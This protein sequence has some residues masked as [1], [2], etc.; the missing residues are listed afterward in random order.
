MELLPDAF[1][2]CVSHPKCVPQCCPESAG[3]VSARQPKYPVLRCSIHSGLAF[4]GKKGLEHGKGG[5]HAGEKRNSLRLPGSPLLSRPLHS[6]PSPHSPF[7]SR[8]CLPRPESP[9]PPG[10]TVKW[11]YSRLNGGVDVPPTEVYSSCSNGAE[12]PKT[13]RVESPVRSFKSL[14]LNDPLLTP[15]PS[16][17]SI[18]GETNPLIGSLLQERQEV[19]ARI[20]QRL[21]FCDPT[22]PHLPDAL[23]APH[24]PPGHKT[25]WSSQQGKERL[26]KPKESLFPVPQLPSHNGTSSEKPE[27]SRSS[28]F[29]TP[30]SPRSRTRL[31]RVDGESKTSPKLS[32]CRR[33]VLSDQSAE[34]SM[35]ADAVQDISRLIQ[36]RLQH[37]YS[38]LNATYKFKT[39]QT[40][41]VGTSHSSQTN[42]FES[43]PSRKKSLNITNGAA[44]TDHP[45]SQATKC[46]RP[47]DSSQSQQ[48][49]FARLQNVASPKLEDHSI[50]KSHLLT[51]SNYRENAKREWCSSSK[52]N[53]SHERSPQENGLTLTG[54]LEPF[55]TKQAIREKGPDKH[56][57]DG[58]SSPK[59]DENQE[60]WTSY[61]STPANLT[62]NTPS[63]A[64][65]Y[66]QSSH[67]V[68]IYSF[69][70]QFLTSW[71]SKHTY[72]SSTVPSYLI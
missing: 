27:R 18:S 61:S 21:N 8:K 2:T 44:S 7:N 23:F 59:K 1:W 13:S 67:T 30:L 42:G 47:P 55:T 29:D 10:K 40:E 15:S 16:P 54:R 12:S 35:I 11:L 37:S 19:I 53:F 49:C 68:S 24:E 46:C 43:P 58:S 20:A 60:P 65:S 33:L 64:L 72:C 45:V 3:S 28:L 32:T 56:V 69:L 36:E 39:A 34:G 52:N 63:H 71:M 62:H 41:Q 17:N 25:P 50:K 6:S 57:K 9:L 22:A 48:D 26:K 70:S 14:S 66:T 38:L 51:A 5:T 31:D 4:L